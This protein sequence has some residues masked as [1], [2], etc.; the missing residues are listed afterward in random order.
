MSTAL[1]GVQLGGQIFRVNF[2]L[3]FVIRTVQQ[4]FFSRYSSS[5]I[6]NA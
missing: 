6:M 5:D 3:E 2:P 4:M 1:E